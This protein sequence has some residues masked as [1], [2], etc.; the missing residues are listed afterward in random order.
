VTGSGCDNKS[1]DAFSGVRNANEQHPFSGHRL[2]G[3]RW[4]Q[5][6]P[7]ARSKLH[8]RMHVLLCADHADLRRIEAGRLAA[9]GSVHYVQIECGGIACEATARRAADLLLAAGGSVS[10]GRRATR[11]FAE[12]TGCGDRESAAR[13][14]DS[15]ARAFDSARHPVAG[16]AV[17]AHYA[18]REFLRDHESRE[19]PAIVRAALRDDPAEAG[20]D[21]ASAR[22][23]DLHLRDDCADVAVRSGRARR[24]GTRGDGSKY[25][26][27]CATTREAAV[28]I[29][30]RSDF[31]A[32]LEPEFQA[33]IADRIGAA[34]E[35]AGRRFA[36]G[37]EGFRWLAQ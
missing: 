31:S 26:R 3:A 30:A 35:K 24:A 4:I 29:S 2:P 33:Q 37:P 9:L 8:V 14:Y 18:T 22:G 27:R 16:G 34:V 11:A 23:R 28:A 10:A 19:R 7:H 6:F 12:I 21:P 36:T 15:N 1:V 5:S 20:D 17:A 25:H 13:V 32:W